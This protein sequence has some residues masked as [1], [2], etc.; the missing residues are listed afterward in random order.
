MHTIH[1]RIFT[2]CKLIHNLLNHYCWSCSQKYKL[3]YKKFHKPINASI[4]VDSLATAVCN[5]KLKS[6]KPNWK[7][8]KKKPKTDKIKRIM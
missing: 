6:M 8:K 5:M 2:G 7:E 4:E 3:K 1:E